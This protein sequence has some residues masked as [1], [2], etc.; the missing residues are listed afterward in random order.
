MTATVS[1][2]PTP[3]GTDPL[4]ES[5]EQVRRSVVPRDLRN[6]L[7]MRTTSFGVSV[8]AIVVGFAVAL[9]MISITGASPGESID[10]LLDGAIGSPSSIASL[11]S[12][13]VPLGLV[14]LGWIVAA[15]AKRVNIG[16]EGQMI[17]GGA[18]S[19]AVGLHL[20]G[21][22]IWVHLPLAVLAGAVGGGAYA[23][24]AALLW[25]R[26]GVNEIFSAL[27]LNLIAVQAV[28]WIIRG[29]L[30]EGG[31][32]FARTAELPETGRWGR[33]VGTYV[34][35]WDWVVLVLAVLLVGVV[36]PRTAAGF[37]LRLVGANPEAATFAG[38]RTARVSVMAFVASGALAG[39]A[40]SSMILAGETYRMTDGFAAEYGYIGIVV[41]LV[42][43]NAALAVIPA[44]IFFAA[45]R[46]GG[47]LLEA[48][49]SV[50]LSIVTITTGTVIV[51]LASASRPIERLRSR[52]LANE[53]ARS[54][55]SLRGGVTPDTPGSPVVDG[56]AGDPDTGVVDLGSRSAE[57]SD[58]ELSDT[59][60]ADSE[61]AVGHDRS[62]VRS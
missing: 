8:G 15:Q 22:P 1:T 48:R 57:I 14:A 62:E 46:Q 43:G 25:H 51:L 54:S 36:L 17:M 6:S 35:S 24:I 39:L 45:L 29:P 23:A 28:A 27:M 21:L 44:A 61:Q 30:A 31:A 42:A 56:A 41:A 26:R 52:R 20:S 12:K 18:A 19:A 4:V 13:A 38:V 59:G 58:P 10:A 60:P 53:A 49:V 32:S 16:L 7:L 55:M 37:R 33:V 9:V 40:G 2:P 34:F 50:P 3:D 11:L 47:G 5:D